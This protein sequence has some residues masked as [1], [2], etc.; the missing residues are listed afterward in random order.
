MLGV[1][2]QRGKAE[3]YVKLPRRFVDRVDLDSAH[4]Y[5]VGDEFRAPKRIDQQKS[6]EPLPL[7]RSVHSQPSDQHDGNIDPGKAL[8]LRRG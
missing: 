2:E 5:L 6:T 7:C 4:P 3:F 1:I 8:R